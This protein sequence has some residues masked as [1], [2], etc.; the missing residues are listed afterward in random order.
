MTQERVDAF[1][2][3]TEDHNYIHVD[4]E[5]AKDTPFGG[6]IAHGYLTVSLLAPIT[7]SLLEVSD[8]KTSINYGMDKLRFP[9]PLPVGAEFR[10]AAEVADVADDRRR[11]AGQAGG[12][13]RGA[14][15]AAAGARRRGSAEVLRMTARRPGGGGDRERA[16]PRSRLRGRAR[17][18]RRRGGGQR[19]RRRRR[20]GDARGD[21]ETAAAG[22]RSCAVGDTAAADAL[23]E[24]AVERVRPA[25]RDGHQRRAAARP[26]AV[27]D[28]RRGLRRG[29]RHPPARHVHLRPGG[30]DPDARAG[31]R[32]GGSSWSA[33]RP[34]S[35]ATSGRRTTRRR[36]P[37][38]SRSRA[39]GRWSW[40]AARSRSTRS[41]RRRGR[42]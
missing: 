10:G 23:V 34:A 3:V 24:R 2:D 32:V 5:R 38:S 20:G 11:R 6:T 36:R 17:A 28:D 12:H 39:P 31:A 29:R 19:R 41:C 25:R 8:A 7:Q 22:A 27:E 15:R 1:A 18:G 40:R 16:R 21:R 4:P 26:R 37:G 14:R 35:T 9:A 33:R 42:G 30:G 13:G